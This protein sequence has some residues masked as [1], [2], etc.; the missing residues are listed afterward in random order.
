MVDIF[1]VQHPN[2]AARADEP[3][4]AVRILEKFE[5]LARD[6]GP[7]NVGM[8]RLAAEL[9]MSTKTTYRHFPNKAELVTAL[10][11]HR[12]EAM[13]AQREAQIE[14]GMPAL[15][16]ILRLTTSWVAHVSSFSPDFWQQLA[17]HFP[18]A[19]RIMD[20]AY[21]AFLRESGANLRRSVREDVDADVALHALKLLIEKAADRD[22]CAALGQPPLA[23]LREHVTVWAR[24]ALR[25][26]ELVAFGDWS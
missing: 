21:D 9:G 8:A 2:L 16:R 1:Q 19:R 26:E 23:V 24:G 20:E 12:H 3:S 6:V 10:I 7:K 22:Y 14:S 17:L 5:Q 18:E 25:P 11:R 15:L 4:Q 13:R